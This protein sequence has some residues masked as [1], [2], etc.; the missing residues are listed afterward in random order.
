MLEKINHVEKQ[1]L[2]DFAL[3]IAKTKLKKHPEIFSVMPTALIIGRLLKG[4]EEFENFL[5]KIQKS[6][7]F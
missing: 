3:E 7:V 2:L 5:E 6:N 4:Q 1:K